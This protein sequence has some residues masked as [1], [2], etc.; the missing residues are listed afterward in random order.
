MWDKYVGAR[1]LLF[2]S[3]AL[4]LALQSPCFCL[5]AISPPDLTLFFSFSAGEK[6]G[7]FSSLFSRERRA[8]QP[9]PKAGA[10]KLS[11]TEKGGGRLYVCV[12][13]GGKRRE[14]NKHTLFPAGEHLFLF[15]S[16]LHPIAFDRKASFLPR[17]FPF[18][19]SLDISPL[20]FRRA[21]CPNK[22]R[23][24]VAL[25]LLG[26]SVEVRPLG[27]VD[28]FPRQKRGKRRILLLFLPHSPPPR[29]V[30]FPLGGE[31]DEEGDGT[32][33]LA[34]FRM[35]ASFLLS[36]SPSPSHIFVC[37]FLVILCSFFFP[38]SS[39]L[40]GGFFLCPTCDPLQKD[41][42]PLRQVL[43]LR[44]V[45]A[46]HL[47][48]LL[49]KLLPKSILV[50]PDVADVLSVFSRRGRQSKLP[51]LLLLEKLLLQEE[52]VSSCVGVAGRLEVVALSGVVRPPIW[53]EEK[54][55]NLHKEEQTKHECMPR[56]PS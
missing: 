56:K 2:P 26:R 52:L 7:L 46:R 23:V 39:F 29:P 16:F 4:L 9:C 50:R 51:L 28:F 5:W 41:I 20:S 25:F 33:N 19:Q 44:L 3:V 8:F 21:D 43:L 36:P 34:L 45:L 31:K 38:L 14:G 53:L 6:T 40:A 35:D 15:F 47:L 32:C 22:W 18:I 1:T 49:S 11:Q 12:C 55:K 24:F 54:G 27:Y 42:V 37:C 13:S 17:L 10:K 48:M 30:I